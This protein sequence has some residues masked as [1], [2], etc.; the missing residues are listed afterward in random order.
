MLLKLDMKMIRGG[1]LA[2]NCVSSTSLTLTGRGEQVQRR[3]AREAGKGER[4]DRMATRG[5]RRWIHALHSPA[6]LPSD[7]VHSHTRFVVPLLLLKYCPPFSPS[8]PLAA[9]FSPLF[10]LSPVVFLQLLFHRHNLTLFAPHV[11]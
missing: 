1:L 9:G 10:F 3:G 2:P 4:C 6:A 5:E 8:L 7:D 11:L